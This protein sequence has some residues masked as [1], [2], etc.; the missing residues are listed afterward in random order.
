MS[1]LQRS[2][3]ANLNMGLRIADDAWNELRNRITVQRRLGVTP[4]ALPDISLAEAQRRSEIGRALLTRLDSIEHE[5]LPHDL[6]LT[7]RLVAFRARTWARE[8]DWYELAADPL[9]VGFFAL[10][11]P[12]A[13]CGG[14]LLNLV[15]RQLAS[16]PFHGSG[17]TD[18]YLALLADYAGLVEQFAIRTAD[19]ADRGIRMPK[20]QVLQ[21][22]DLLRAFKAGARQAIGVTP[23]RVRTG[24]AQT[25]LREVELRITSVVES[26]FES[27]LRL[28][29]DDYFAAAP[30]AVGMGQY[31]GGPE[32]Y[33]E[34]VRLHTTLELAPEEIHERGLARVGELEDAMER[35][36]GQLGFRVGNAEFLAHLSNDVR[37]RA[38]TPTAVAAVFQRCLDRL[39][40]HFS[41]NFAIS[42]RARCEVTPLPASLQGAMSYGYYEAPRRDIPVGRYLFNAANL[43]AQPVIRLA[44]LTYHELMPGHHLHLATQQENEF[45]HPFRQYSFVN[46]YN[47][48]WAEYAATLA[49]ELGL[50][51]QPEERY[52]RLLNEALLACRLVVDTGMNAFGWSLQRARGYLRQH[53]GLP[54]A[55]ID[56][57][58]VRY[59][60]D[61]PAQALAYKIGDA[62]IL[63]LRER[64]RAALRAEFRL[65]TFHSAVLGPGALPL[66]D[67]QWHVEHEIARH[68]AHRI[69]E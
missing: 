13:Y 59:S 6:A 43:M 42:P 3:D 21:A 66:L 68:T 18:H 48:G 1:K 24:F 53:S 46:A 58:T 65:K 55:E 64:M 52:G 39:A 30:E 67:L 12:T 2:A 26:A 25:F 11:Y 49:A 27:V 45:L 41:E 20:V 63:S 7:L 37:W 14:Q 35:V 17:S 56:S 33:R 51:E 15:H 34:L 23:E 29:G 4:A 44:G 61:V 50:Y 36:R 54:E 60:C 9:G 31:P 10:F 40:P 69:C 32:L 19:Q 47:E 38:S 5:N 22:R 57:E 16:F 62:H 8:A 28:L